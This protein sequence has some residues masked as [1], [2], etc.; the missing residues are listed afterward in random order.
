MRLSSLI[1]Q[2]FHQFVINYKHLKDKLSQLPKDDAEIRKTALKVFLT[3]MHCLLAI[4]ISCVTLGMIRYKV[5]PVLSILF[6]AGM[7][8]LNPSATAASFSLTFGFMA[9][10]LV[11]YGIAKKSLILLALALVAGI[12]QYANG[13]YYHYLVQKDWER[14]E[15]YIAPRLSR[16]DALIHENSKVIDKI[17]NW[18]S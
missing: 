7:A 9:I 12:K 8:L 11:T 5:H 18:A 10:A 17:I 16:F 13:L 4:A 3:G 15:Y 2:P 6:I 14:L 1:P